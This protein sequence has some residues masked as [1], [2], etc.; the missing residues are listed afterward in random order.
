GNTTTTS[1]TFTI[2]DTAAPTIDVEAADLTVECDGNGN[3]TDLQDWLDNNGGASAS[4]NCSNVTWSNDFSALSDDCGAT[5]SA[6]VTFTATDECGNTTTTSA[7]FTIQD[8]AAPTVVGDFEEEIF[9]TCSE[10]PGIPELVFEDSCSSEITVEFNESST[11]DGSDN[12]YEITYEWIVGDECGNEDIFIQTVFVTVE[13]NVEGIDTSLCIDDS[14]IDL[15]DFL[16]GDFN[17]DGSWLVTFG[18]ATLEEGSIFN[19]EG[20]ELGTYVITYTDN[21]GVC[22]TDTTVTIALNDDCVVL[23]CGSEDVV[24]SKAVTANGDQFNEFFTVTGIEDCGYVIE[25]Q[26]FNRWGAK[27]FESN[28]YQN[29]WNGSAHSN[30]VGSSNQVPTGTYYY[31]VNLRGSGLRPFSGPIYV[32]TR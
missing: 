22:P 12:D 25:L 26:I 10:L 31:I 16:S 30:S 15:F 19:P 9:V 2:Q 32:G 3:T 18:D 20:L 6:T 14:P 27:I 13:S 17:P 28:N 1:A 21:S 8:T 11:F 29:D 24:I 7:T 5:G 23:A 4:D